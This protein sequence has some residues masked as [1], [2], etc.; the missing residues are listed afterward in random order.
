M[1]AVDYDDDNDQ[2]LGGSGVGHVVTA[3]C[4]SKCQA[5]PP[6]DHFERLLKEAWPNDA[7]PIKHKLKDCGMMKNF[8]ISRSLT[9]G[10]ELDE[11]LGGS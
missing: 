6:T 5:W 11:Y 9:Y 8:L 1:A 2:E 7:Y 3:V 10:M 4:S